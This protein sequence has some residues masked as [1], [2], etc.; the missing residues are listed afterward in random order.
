[1]NH[2]T[3]LHQRRISRRRVLQ[4]AAALGGT[5][6]AGML[7]SACSSS[8]PGRR[9]LK[10]VKLTQAVDSLAYAQN[11]IAR[12]KGYYAEQGLAVETIVTDGGGPDVQAVLAGSAM[13]T[14]NDGAQVLTSFKQDRKLTAVAAMFDKCLVNA[15]ISTKAAKRAGITEGSSHAK[16]VE[17][18]RGLRIG[19]TAP[20]ALTWQIARYNLRN[21]GIDPDKDAEL[22]ALGGGTAVVAALEN[23]QVDAVYI[24]IPFG[25]A[26]V[27]RGNA[28]TLIDHSSGEDPKLQKFMMEGLWVTPETM[29]KDSGTVQAMVAAL[30]K[31]SEFLRKSSEEE[32][33][34][35]LRSDFPKFPPKVLK[36]AA[37]MLKSAL[38]ADH[39]WDDEGVETTI[40]VLKENKLLPASVSTKDRIFEDRYI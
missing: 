38:P 24:S 28:I 29:E 3:D 13:F 30:T 5:A 26:A 25:E 40:S 19:V 34:E 31:A 22:V 1:M 39:R 6:L 11:Y 14:I 23:D 15:T 32:V 35:T 17:A 27:A 33:V 37:G 18:L 2:V 36:T 7:L 4:G 12:A 9:G 20:G 21:A 16:R 10:S 8:A